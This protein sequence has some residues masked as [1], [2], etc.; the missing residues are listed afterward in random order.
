MT[1]LRI[2]LVDDHAVVRAGYRRLLELEDDVEVA[3]EFADAESAYLAL[4]A[5]DGLPVDLLVTD[6]SLPGRSGLDLLR[7]LQQRCPA[8]PVL[9]FTMHDSPAMVVQCLRA[10][11]AGFVTKSSAPQVLVDAIRH[12]AHGEP[13][14][15]PDVADAARG[16]AALPPHLRL[17]TREF[18]VLQALL[19][20][21]GVD[22]ISARLNLSRK[23][24]ANYQTLVRQKLGVANAV[25]LMRYAREHGLEG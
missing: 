10:G 15:S 2:G 19:Q 7:R 13:A 24:V 12:A 16:G 18:D 1:R 9:V 4:S 11:A 21:S 22:E 5:T 23:T 6:L 3:A 20:G 8:L 17:S 14:L 25:E